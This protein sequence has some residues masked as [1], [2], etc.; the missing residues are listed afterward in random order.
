[1]KLPL[2]I[3]GAILLIAGAALIYYKSRLR[4]AIKKE[5]GG[6]MPPY[7]LKELENFLAE[8]MVT[9]EY[10]IAITVCDSILKVDSK[11]F[12][13]LSSRAISLGAQDYHLEAIEDYEK[14]LM[15]DNSDKN[16]FGLLGLAQFTIGDLENAEKNLKHSVDNGMKIYESN[17]MM[18]KMLLEMPDIGNS[19]REK[20]DAN[21]LLKRRNITN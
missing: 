19:L 1:M 16:L 14:A 7:N 13:A 8:K 9:K 6:T 10:N 17:L 12:F 4:Q 20:A 5:N 18:A 15:I 2:I 11:N 3:S 21:G